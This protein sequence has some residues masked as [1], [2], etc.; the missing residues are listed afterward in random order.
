M[1]FHVGRPKVATSFMP[2]SGALIPTKINLSQWR[3]AEFNINLKVVGSP[4]ARISEELCAWV[5]RKPQSQ[6][7]KENLKDF[8]K[9][10]VHSIPFFVR[11]DLHITILFCGFFFYCRF[12]FF[13]VPWYWLFKYS[14]APTTQWQGKYRNSPCDTFQLKN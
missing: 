6:L 5:C 11:K 2:E 4:D 12:R 10:K 14:S 3:N 13:K 1:F 8:C 9:D 7:S